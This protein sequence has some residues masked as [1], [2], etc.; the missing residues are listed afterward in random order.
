M[1]MDPIDKEEDYEVT[2]ILK[3]P[4]KKKGL[5]AFRKQLDDF[6]DKC[7]TVDSG[8]SETDG[9]GTSVP[10]K[11]KVREGRSGVRRTLA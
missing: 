8:F 1:G 2:I 3:G 5:R 10:I 9:S 11:L 6:L 4:V 7:E